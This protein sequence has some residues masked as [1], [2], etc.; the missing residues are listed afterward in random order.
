MISLQIREISGNPLLSCSL[1]SLFRWASHL[2]CS[3]ILSNSLA[4]VLLKAI[5][6]FFSWVLWYCYLFLNCISLHSKG[7]DTSNTSR[8]LQFFLG[9]KINFKVLNQVAFI[10]LDNFSRQRFSMFFLFVT[11]YLGFLSFNFSLVDSDFFLWSDLF[12]LLLACITS[13]EKFGF[14]RLHEILIPSL[15]VENFTIGGGWSLRTTCGF[16]TPFHAIIA[17]GARAS[18][19][20]KKKERQKL[21]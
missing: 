19:P 16:A 1:F 15:G 3:L 5:S 9:T 14:I 20:L 12:G 6:S 10:G 13:Y 4:S 18:V 17:F 11:T 8:H 7:S 21:R 2:C